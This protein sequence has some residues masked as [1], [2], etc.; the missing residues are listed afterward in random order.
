MNPTT[1]KYH[2]GRY[3]V[4]HDIARGTHATARELQP[5][6]FMHA[7]DTLVAAGCR[8]RCKPNEF[9]ILGLNEAD[10]EDE[11]NTCEYENDYF[12]HAGL[13]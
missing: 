5:T 2:T 8:V 3:A 13:L 4:A 12:Q 11:N 6:K 1:L 7:D 10:V 9:P